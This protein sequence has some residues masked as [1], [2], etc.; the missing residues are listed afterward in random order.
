MRTVSVAGQT[1]RMLN[2]IG[3][4]QSGTRHNARQLSELCGVSRRTIFRDLAALQ[5]AGLPAH[6]DSAQQAYWLPGKAF[7][8]PTGFALDEALA[9]LVLCQNL[10]AKSGFPF[11]I[12]A[13][14]AAT[15]I[16]SLLPPALRDQTQAITRSIGIRLPPR[17]RLS[18]EQHVYE[19]LVHS[20]QHG[21]CVRISYQGMSDKTPFRTKLSPYRLFFSRRAWYVIGRSSSH[22]ALRTF[23]LGRIKDIEILEDVSHIPPRFSLDRKLGNAWHMIRGKPQMNVCVRFEPLVAGNVAEVLWHKTQRCERLPDGRLEFHATVD[24][25]DE[26]VWWILGYGDQAEVL[27]PPELRQRVAEHARRLAA[28]YA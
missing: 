24:G 28:R 11:Q 13:H 17:H 3:L 7:L 6:F 20:L 4:L 21:R 5:M 19:R 18:A 27:A 14:S 9:L 22:R 15:K 10:G 25:M 26:I 23:H 1:L 16:A 2:L 12:A 8:P